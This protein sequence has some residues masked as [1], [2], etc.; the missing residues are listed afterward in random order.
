M[1]EEKLKLNRTE[2]LKNWLKE[3]SN[4]IFVVIF[5]LGIAIRIYYFSLTK[6]QPLWWDEADYMAYAK[7]LAGIGNV[8]W[9]ISSKHNSLFPYLV[10]A[11]FKFGFSEISIKFLLELLPSILFL[12]DSHGLFRAFLAIS[13]A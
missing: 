1:E 8:D 11:L 9:I 4:F 2:K 3:P 12:P 13:T 7:N 6:S 5:L 10:A